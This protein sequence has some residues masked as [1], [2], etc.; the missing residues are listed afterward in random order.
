M[1][2]FTYFDVAGRALPCRV[3]LFNAFGKDGW[4]DE[5]LSFAEFGEKKAAGAF[6]L[7][8]LPT[9]TL[10][11]G[12]QLCQSMAITVWAGKQGTQPLYPA[13]PSEGLVVEEVFQTAYELMGKAPQDPDPE[14]KKQKRLEFADG[15]MKTFM[16]MLDKRYEGKTFLLK[17]ITIADLAVLCLVAMIACGDWDYVDPS[18]L[19]GFPNLQKAC[20]AIKQHPTVKGY[21]EIYPN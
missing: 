5:R 8:S 20:E 15:G 12:R 6:P 13:D 19:D 9:L 10:A 1:A 7:G 21:Y 3:A 14:V 16:G 2:K 4:T 18:Y 17:D 11:D